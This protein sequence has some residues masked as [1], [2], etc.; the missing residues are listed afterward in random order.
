MKYMNKAGDV[1]KELEYLKNSEKIKVFKKFFKT[2]KG[3]YGYGDMFWGLSVPQ[4]REISKRYFRDISFDE[5]KILIN[6]RIHEVRLT[7]YLI[8]TY[9]YEKSDNEKRKDIFDFYLN[10]LSGCNNWDLVD[11]S[12]YKIVG[13]YVLRNKEK[14]KILYKL[15]KSKNLWEQR[16]SIVSTYPMIKR[17]EFE[18]TLNISKLLLFHKHDLIHKAV[19]WMLREVGKQDM[20]VLRKFLNENINTI[21]RTTLRYSIEKMNKSERKKYLLKSF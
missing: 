8:L 4:V 11:L 6:H 16:I 14:R 18:D 20:N 5:I 17:K 12:C 15:S 19:G 2:N 1:V 21:P 3:E 7:G 10:N 9:Q 13:E